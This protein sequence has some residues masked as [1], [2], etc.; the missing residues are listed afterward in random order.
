[1]ICE[2]SSK[3][4]YSEVSAPLCLLLAA[5]GRGFKK[6]FLF[7]KQGGPGPRRGRGGGHLPGGAKLI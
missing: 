1:M 7:S 3:F 2:K 4:S 5:Q 6:M